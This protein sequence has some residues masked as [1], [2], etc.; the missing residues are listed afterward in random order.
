MWGICKCKYSIHLFI[1]VH[2]CALWICEALAGEMTFL[3]LE[4]RCR[5][6]ESWS[7][8]CVYICLDQRALEILVSAI[9]VLVHVAALVEGLAY[10]AFLLDGFVKADVS[11]YVSL[12]SFALCLLGC[13]V[14]GLG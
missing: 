12:S 7:V 5:T 9:F 1:S 3:A 11:P 13:L 4:L 14:F 8:S 2:I 10:M 6:V